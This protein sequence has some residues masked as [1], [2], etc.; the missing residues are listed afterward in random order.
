MFE[1]DDE[2]GSV[3]KEI[4]NAGLIIEKKNETWKIK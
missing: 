2:V 3:F 4:K 1:S